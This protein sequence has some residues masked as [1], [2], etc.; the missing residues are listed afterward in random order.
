M[1]DKWGSDGQ[2]LI[3]DA[4]YFGAGHQ[5]EDKLHFVYYAGGRELIGDP[6]IYSYKMDEFEPYWR[7]SW[8][9]NTV[10]IDGFSQHRSLGPKEQV[11]DPDRRFVIGE[12][13]DFA[14]GWYRH[15]YSPRTGGLGSHSPE[16][17]REA[18]IRDVQHQRCVFCVKG[19][20]AV[21]CDRVVGDGE[22]QIDTIFRPAP[23]L[24]AEGETHTARAVRLEVRPDGAVLTREPGHSNVAILPAQREDLE[25]LDL[26]GQ[27]DPVRGWYALYGIVPSHDI[28]YR[29]RRTLPQHFQ[30]VV[31]PLLAAGNAPMT[32]EPLDVTGSDARTCAALRCGPDLFLLS[33]DGPSEMTC[34]DVRFHG[35]ALLL[36]DGRAF[37]V[38]ARSL[39]VGNRAILAKDAPRPAQSIDLG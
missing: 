31:Q 34:G 39:A 18:A 8:S 24:T 22:H 20:Y 13:F 3:F 33:Y 30:T 11:P 15:A 29:R 23:V 6:G 10:V 27:K 35:T 4:G 26:V 5:H 32:V 36:R 25:V 14:V 9:H 2:V 19:E 17:D 7:G 21:I 28:V 37:M 12:G 1:R 38:D 16:M